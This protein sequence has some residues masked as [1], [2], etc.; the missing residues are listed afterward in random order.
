MGMAPRM[1]E[2]FWDT[3]TQ[4]LL[5]LHSNRTSN[6]NFN[7]SNQDRCDLSAASLKKT[8]QQRREDTTSSAC[9]WGL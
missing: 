8:A 3:K 6:D 4:A 7:Q 9:A 2:G 5:I 1:A